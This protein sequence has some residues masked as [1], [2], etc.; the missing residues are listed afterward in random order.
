MRGGL[1]SRTVLC[2]RYHGNSIANPMYATDPVVQAEVDA[3][4]ENGA[5]G[6]AEGFWRQPASRLKTFA[7]C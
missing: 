7:A 4:K 1:V 2:P 6:K 5:D 3:A